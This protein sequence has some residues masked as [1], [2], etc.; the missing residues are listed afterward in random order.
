MYGITRIDTIDEV[1]LVSFPSIPV[2]LPLLAEI[3]TAVADEDILIDMVSQTAPVGD[4]I[5][6]AFTCMDSDMVKVLELTRQ[7]QA[8]YPKIKPLVS[9]GNSKI[10]LYG[11]EMRVT[12]GVFARMLSCLAGLD[13]EIKQVTTSEVD[14][15]LLVSEADLEQSVDALAKGFGLAK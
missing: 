2:D 4:K 7:L 11:E 10:Q 1:T 5:G 14:I 12:P 13:I 6:I 9:N 3:F 8:K 15:S